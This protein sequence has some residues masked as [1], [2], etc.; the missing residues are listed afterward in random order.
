MN[1]L[2]NELAGIRKPGEEGGLTINP[3]G[4]SRGSQ[5]KRDAWV[6]KLLAKKF[7]VSFMF[8]EWLQLI[9]T[10][11][12]LHNIICLRLCSLLST[13]GLSA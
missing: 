12:A 7:S 8:P 5:K 4:N 11:K 13:N 10:H 2:F 9:V 1:E 3:T 6:K